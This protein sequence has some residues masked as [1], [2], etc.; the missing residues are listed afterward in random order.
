MSHLYNTSVIIV[1]DIE[2]SIN[3]MFE[4]KYIARLDIEIIVDKVPKGST[5]SLIYNREHS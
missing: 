5:L 4:V 1:I 3:L 2:F